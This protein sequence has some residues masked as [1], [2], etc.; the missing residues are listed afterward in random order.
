MY[1]IL[2][3]M[4]QTAYGLE[5]SCYWVPQCHRHSICDRRVRG[6]GA[7]VLCIVWD[8]KNVSGGEG[9]EYRVI[10]YD[11]STRLE[12]QSQKFAW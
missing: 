3:F 12:C 1:A 10:L 11:L 9:Q 8:C 5:M 6:W 2:K 7:G 4:D